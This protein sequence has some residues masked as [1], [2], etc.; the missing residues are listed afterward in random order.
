MLSANEMYRFTIV[1]PAVTNDGQPSGYRDVVENVLD[2][3]GIVS[4]TEHQTIGVWHGARE[5]GTLFEVYHESEN[6]NGRLREI[7]LALRA[8]MPDQEA[9]Q[10]TRDQSRT[11]VWEA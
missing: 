5:P 11:V 3:Y 6:L 8:G 4:W 7:M 9:I 10:V 1:A 2:R